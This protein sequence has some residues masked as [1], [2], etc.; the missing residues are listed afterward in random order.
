MI[1]E[2]CQLAP[3][4]AQ[5]TVQQSRPLQVRHKCR[6]Y[7]FLGLPERSFLDTA[8]GRNHGMPSGSHEDG[9]SQSVERISGSVKF[10][11]RNAGFNLLTRTSLVIQTYKGFRQGAG[12]NSPEIDSGITF[13]IQPFVLV[14]PA[15]HTN[16]SE[17]VPARVTQHKSASSATDG[18]EIT[19]EKQRPARRVSH[20]VVDQAGQF[21]CGF[22]LNTTHA[23]HA[24]NLLSRRDVQSSRGHIEVY[25]QYD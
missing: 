10:A 25:R 23:S 1:G 22:S 9:S 12:N 11:V 6:Q 19:F 20:G 17:A 4:G 2:R 18:L 24:E 21:E 7:G 13:A 14:G 5:L 15:V 16:S 8:I 3:K